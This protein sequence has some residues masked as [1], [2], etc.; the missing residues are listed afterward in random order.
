MGRVVNRRLGRKA[1]KH[2]RI[3]QSAEATLTTVGEIT[4]R[5][6]SD[7]QITHEEF[8]QVQN[9]SRRFAELKRT[10]RESSR[11]KKQAA[12]LGK[13]LEKSNQQFER[14]KAVAVAA[15]TAEAGE[16]VER[17]RREGE[18]QALKKNRD[19]SGWRLVI[20]FPR[21]APLSTSETCR[22]FFALY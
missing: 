18:A 22:S 12:Y 14:E 11:I 1:K 4:S 15:A 7:S 9:Q 6:L 8:Q 13:V 21:G 20:D 17:T 16:R 3:A 2:D 10:I 5:A 19:Q